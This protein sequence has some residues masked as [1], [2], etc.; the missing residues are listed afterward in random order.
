MWWVFAGTKGGR[1]RQKLVEALLSKPMNPN[2]LASQLNVNYRTIVHH[3][4][5]LTENRLIIAEGPNHGKVYFPSQLLLQN[6]HIFRRVCLEGRK[7]SQEVDMK[8]G[9]RV[10]MV[11]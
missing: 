2:Q 7:L 8:D 1:M 11:L 9:N 10:F 3:L 6:L 4:E 5:V